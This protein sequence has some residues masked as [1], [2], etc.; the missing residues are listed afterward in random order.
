MI[1]RAYNVTAV[2]FNQW[3]S[4]TWPATVISERNCHTCQI[5]M[6]I[7]IGKSCCCGGAH[8]HNNETLLFLGS[9]TIIVLSIKIIVYLIEKFKEKD[10]W[11]LLGTVKT[12]LKGEVICEIATWDVLAE[13][14]PLL[15]ENAPYY[16]P[17]KHHASQA[18]KISWKIKLSCNCSGNIVKRSLFLA[19]SL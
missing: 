5:C 14:K 16:Q 4:I 1:A 2:C 19:S 3:T 7:K 17:G 8:T 10:E 13:L 6:V 12:K 9:L 15:P 18:E 11:I